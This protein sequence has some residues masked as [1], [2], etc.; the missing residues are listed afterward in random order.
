MYTT[1]FVNYVVKN[2]ASRAF[3]EKEAQFFDLNLLKKKSSC[4]IH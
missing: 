1:M 4:R 3:A 2:I